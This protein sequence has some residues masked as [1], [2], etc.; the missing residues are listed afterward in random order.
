MSQQGRLRAAGALAVVGTLLAGCGG[1]VAR[2]MAGQT[3]AAQASGSVLV[4]YLKG[5]EA[6]L[7]STDWSGH[8]QSTFPMPQAPP[9]MPHYPGKTVPA[10]LWASSVSPDG[11]RL[12]L[13]DGSIR[14][15]V[16]AKVAQLDRSAGIVTWADDN[17]H[18][19]GMTTPGYESFV[20]GTLTGPAILSWVTPG[21][22]SRTVATVGQFGP[23]ATTTVEAC[24]AHTGMAVLTERTASAIT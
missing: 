18:F 5:S 12:V 7:L 3:P 24:S 6:A 15:P 14:D 8:H 10:R 21:S 17:R 23:N 20:G 19:C 1:T 16:G 4:W 11:S 22:A 2:P 9:D 13:R